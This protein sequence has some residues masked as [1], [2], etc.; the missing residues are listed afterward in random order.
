MA[1][2]IRM[3]YELMDNMKRAFVESAK[4]LETTLAEVQS[5]AN[6]LE[7]SG[8]NDGALLG[9]G[10]QAFTEAIRVKLSPAISRLRDRFE[11]LGERVDKAKAE[12]QAAD[13]QKASPRFSN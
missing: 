13:Q 2:E 12:M 6:D 10:G 9:D 11:S 8:S 5:I 3:D 4:Q 7:G 1:D